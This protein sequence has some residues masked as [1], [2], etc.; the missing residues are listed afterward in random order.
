MTKGLCFVSSFRASEVE[1]MP[2]P[3]KVSLFVSHQQFLCS[4]T[5]A[6]ATGSLQLPR[7]QSWE[8]ANLEAESGGSYMG[9]SELVSQYTG[10]QPISWRSLVKAM[11]CHMS[12]L[13][14]AS[15]GLRLESGRGLFFGS[16]PR[17]TNIAR[18]FACTTFQQLPTR[19]QNAPPTL[20]HRSLPQSSRSAHRKLHD[21]RKT[22]LC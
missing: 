19:L 11:T 14:A 21:M 1:R 6:T 8:E 4:Q 5:Q 13:E 22:P 18:P 3:V 2:M 9:H 17:T 20:Q 10:I 7:R 15:S 16:P 12:L